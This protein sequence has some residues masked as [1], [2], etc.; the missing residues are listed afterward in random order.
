MMKNNNN[1]LKNNKHMKNNNKHCNKE[2]QQAHQLNANPIQFILG[3]CVV[4]GVSSISVRAADNPA[5]A[6]ARVALEQ[7]MNELDRLQTP[8]PVPV[9]LS[10]AMLEQPGESAAKETG[11]VSVKA[12]TPQTAPVP[13]TPVAASAAL[14][15]AMSHLKLSLLILS[16]FIPLLL[17][18]KLLLRY[19]RGYGSNQDSTSSDTYNA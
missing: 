16:L 6:A 17:L 8:L 5:Q 9:T 11:T 4:L 3:L 10:K 18:L 13:T 14:V 1:K 19:S 12:V 2:N 15:P 7:K